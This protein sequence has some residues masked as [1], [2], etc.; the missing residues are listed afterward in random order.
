M[1][2]RSLR[3]EIW[4]I[5]AN[6][7]RLVHNVT[8]INATHDV[9]NLLPHTVSDPFSWPTAIILSSRLYVTA[10]TAL[11]TA[12]CINIGF[13]NNMLVCLV[14]YIGWKETIRCLL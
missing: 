4:I 6:H 12:L 13:M 9:I 7:Y 2:G 1:I 8:S 10:V 5:K 3:L 11:D 14:T